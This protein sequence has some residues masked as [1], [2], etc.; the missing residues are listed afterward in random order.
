MNWHYHCTIR[1]TLL[2]QYRQNMQN[3]ANKNTDRNTVM[4]RITD[5]IGI[6]N[7]GSTVNFCN[8]SSQS[9]KCTVCQLSQ[10]V[11]SRW[12]HW[13]SIQVRPHR[14][15]RVRLESM[16]L[17]S[18]TGYYRGI[19]E[20][21]GLESKKDNKVNAQTSTLKIRRLRP[22]PLLRGKC[23]VQN[24]G[25]EAS[26]VVEALTSLFISQCTCNLWLNNAQA[27]NWQAMTCWGT[28]L[29]CPP[30]HK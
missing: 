9:H 20:W 15:N 5:N 14:P 24:S 27:G 26:L 19:F 13:C 17:D 21:H 30:P 22:R 2:T 11:T 16:D 3:R 8:S 29:P 7:C 4:L 23:Q 10:S 25:L 6:S 12:R 18:I 28:W 1:L